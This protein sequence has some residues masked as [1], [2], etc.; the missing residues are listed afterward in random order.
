MYIS[1]F[2]QK[3][4]LSIVVNGLK[5]SPSRIRMSSSSANSLILPLL[6]DLFSKGSGRD[7]RDIPFELSRV[8]L[9]F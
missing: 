5:R 7:Q 6:D 9:G 1:V 3:L 2:L 8:N 4:H